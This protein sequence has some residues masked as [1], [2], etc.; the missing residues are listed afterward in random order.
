MLWSSI[1]Y[2]AKICCGITYV[3]SLAYIVEPSILL[4]GA[5]SK[6][7][8]KLLLLRLLLHKG[9]WDAEGKGK[10]DKGKGKGGYA[11]KGGFGGEKGQGKGY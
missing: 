11:G 4:W 7:A 3:I 6:V 9:V 1:C 10:G 2:I 5:D 8:S